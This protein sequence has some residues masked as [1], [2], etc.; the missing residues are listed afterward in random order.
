MR[1]WNSVLA[2][3]AVSYI[4]IVLVIVLSLCSVFY[5]YYSDRDRGQMRSRSKMTLEN[6]AR[7]LDSEVFQRVQQT[8][9]GLA[10]DKNTDLRQ[11]RGGSWQTHPAKLVELQELLQSEV[12][13]SPELIE[14]IHLYEPSSGAMLSSLYGLV[15]AAS[16][17]A[18]A[19]LPSDWI[20]G[21]L[22]SG[23]RH[24]WTPARVVPKDPFSQIPGGSGQRLITYAHT[25]PFQSTGADSQLILAVDIKEEAIRG[26]LRNMLPF[27][28]EE[29]WLRS[30]SGS[31]ML[32]P[33]TADEQAGDSFSPVL[34]LIDET[35]G[36]AANGGEVGGWV[37][38][39]SYTVFREPLPSAGWTLYSATAHS[40][41]REQSSAVLKLML[42]VCALAIVIG[43]LLSGVMTR[44]IYSP[45][46]ALVGKIRHLAGQSDAAG[47]NEYGM[48]D[49][50][51]E[52]LSG[53][54]VSLEETLHAAR[55][56]VKRE[57][58]LKLLRGEAIEPTL[59]ETRLPGEWFGGHSR[60]R[61]LVLDIGS[62]PAGTDS[63]AA[64]GILGEIAA[65]LESQNTPGSRIVTEELSSRRLVAILAD[66]PGEAGPQAGEDFFGSE[67]PG[68]RTMPDF[69]QRFAEACRQRLDLR[70][71]LAW[72][73]SVDRP[74]R[75]PLSL[76]EAES[77]LKYAYF[78]PERS[79]LQDAGLLERERST[80]EIPQAMLS[81]FRDKLAARQHAEI[82]AAVDDLIEAVRTGSYSADYGHFVLAN[83]VFLYSDHLKS[84]RY[85]QPNGGHPDLHR[86]Y[87]ELP[88]IL[89]FRVWLME[90]V[91]LFLIETEKRNGERAT[92]TLESAKRYI[93]ENLSG[94]LSLEAVSSSVFISAK[95]LSRLF[96]EELGVTYTEYVTARRMET[97]RSL[98]ELGS[99]TIEQ[100]AAAVGYGTPAY[101]IKKFKEAYGCTPG[102][103]LREQAKQAHSS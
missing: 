44:L 93:A 35:D 67:D 72:G 68:E 63:E 3:L 25:Y 13:G 70:I 32:G 87:V 88:H 43:L 80:E 36:S 55:P 37:D 22:T 69:A 2:R 60:L 77:R 76:G 31:L 21:M 56:L 86:Q 20:D 42:G 38:S 98:V 82:E 4:A 74:G 57:T 18:A 84:I 48:I 47:A 40:L 29:T 61:C 85:K 81:R 103:Y 24:F 50:A 52:H 101:F 34:R 97:A 53:R 64:D 79:I 78:L 11:F 27:Q 83:I 58:L 10:L 59:Q 91:S 90:S 17:E 54:V 39:E 9:L 46:K 49:T 12:S 96:K 5:L 75:L 89:E 26:I 99:L 6:T 33:E 65:L 94:D 51:L 41:Y 100:V 19:S 62:L 28:Y 15:D 16:R 30:D 71:Q 66:T 92:D 23:E 8:A 14:A 1:K 102:N 73:R 45:L 95:Y 7:T